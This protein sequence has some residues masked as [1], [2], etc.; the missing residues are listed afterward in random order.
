MPYM[1]GLSVLPTT[2]SRRERS[3]NTMPAATWPTDHN[4]SPLKRQTAIQQPATNQEL[5]AER[6]DQVP[7]HR[8]PAW[9]EVEVTDCK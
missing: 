6:L 4:R 1:V 8:G 9:A 7:G 3:A 2:I 5:G